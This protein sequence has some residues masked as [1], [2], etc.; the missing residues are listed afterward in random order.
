MSMQMLTILQLTGILA[1][2]L[3]MTVLLPAFVF[4]R[5]VSEERFCVRFMIYLVIGNVYLMNMVMV[6][7]LLHISNRFTL[8]LGTILPVLWAMARVHNVTV[9]DGI[10][11]AARSVNSFLSGTMGGRL[12]LSKIMRFIGRCLKAGLLRLLR[13]IRKNFFDWGFTAGCIV[14]ILWLYGSNLIWNMGYCTSDIPVHNYWINAMSR[15]EMFIAGVYPHGF[16]SMMYYLHEVFGFRTFELLRVFCL[17][18]NVLVHMTLLAFLKVCCRTKYSP[19][20]AM[21]MYILANIWN[22]DT[23][24]RYFSTLPQ[25]F[26]MIFILPSICFLYAFLEDRARENRA[27]GWKQHSTRY[28]L[29]FALSFSATLAA[30]FYNTMIA[31][32][33]CVGVAMGFMG[34]VFRREYFGRIML[35]GILSIVLAVMPMA[36]AFAMGRP[37]EGSLRWGM[38]IIAGP[39]EESGDTDQGQGSSA[40]E[41]TGQSAGTQAVTGDTGQSAGTGQAV[42]GGTGQGQ[43]SSGTGGTQAVT[44]STGQPTD[45]QAVTGD[46]GQSAGTLPQQDGNPSGGMQG[47]PEGAAIQEN[48]P[49]PE[50]KIPLKVRMK[51]WVNEKWKKTV[52]LVRGLRDTV[53]LRIMNRISAET[54]A[55]VLFVT[56][57]L[58][59]L[60]L[61]GLTARKT[62]HYGCILLSAGFCLLFLYVVLMAV[63]F[64]IPALMDQTRCSIYLAYLMS[65][66]VALTADA[67]SGLVLGKITTPFLSDMISLAGGGMMAFVIV[68]GGIYKM[69]LSITALESNDAIT[70]LT[71]ILRDNPRY[72]FTVCSAN[73][74]LRMV[75]DYGYHYEVIT[76]LQAMEGERQEEYLTIPTPKVYFFIEKIP[77]DYTMPYEGSGRKVSEVGAYRPLPYGSGLSVYKGPN[78][79]TVMSKMYYWAL[80]FKKM[81][82]NEMR[83]YYETDAFICYE[84]EQNPYRLF[85][86]SIDYGYNSYSMTDE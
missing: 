7:Q 1:A 58:S 32:I 59:V 43:G 12:L 51:F 56:A 44:G 13:S 47:T 21:I 10:L 70:C 34:K 17:V 27:K 80:A 86:F 14:A 81:Y 20:I 28:L 3:G 6:L 31:G 75:E 71:N 37:L 85:D 30:H 67:L 57:A 60:G 83:V 53:Q 18:Q 69:P 24:T 36:V 65:A 72:Q 9:K 84:V 11:G 19:Y 52:N 74:E 68:W 41:G 49:P 38:S 4:Y 23:F 77:I 79:Y 63:W 66:A 76:F 45:T 46:T 33:F 25:E 62:R 15:N 5:K 35:A 8:I 54:V 73:D 64:G 16:H 48:T 78:R 50:P 40:A 82:P 39:K 22:R 26:G 42:T 61:L 29:F 55:A 2:Y